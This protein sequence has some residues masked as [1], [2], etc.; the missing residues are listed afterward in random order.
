MKKQKDETWNWIAYTF[1]CKSRERWQCIKFWDSRNLSS[2]PQLPCRLSEILTGI[3][4]G[5][6]FFICKMRI[7]AYF[8]SNW[9]K[10]V[11]GYTIRFLS[12]LD[13]FGIPVMKIWKLLLCPYFICWEEN[14]FQPAELALFALFWMPIFARQCSYYWL[15]TYLLVS[16]LP[17][18]HITTSPVLDVSNSTWFHVKP[19]YSSYI[20]NDKKPKTLADGWFPD[21]FSAFSECW[22]L[23]AR[24]YGISAFP[25]AVRSR[26]ELSAN[27]P[28]ANTLLDIAVLNWSK[29]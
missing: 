23:K 22:F 19:V 8:L 16:V 26:W 6:Q 29:D 9:A 5:L 4:T 27:A 11:W 28:E 7:I 15:R 10:K 1:C 24:N 25:G 14:S 3:T 20:F 17:F 13:P 18:G 12:H 21:V 2:L